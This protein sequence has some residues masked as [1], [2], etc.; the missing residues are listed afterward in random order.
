MSVTHTINVD[1]IECNVA[2]T[3]QVVF[4][5]K[6]TL[7]LGKFSLWLLGEGN[8]YYRRRW[9]LSYANKNIGIVQYMLITDQW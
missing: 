9:R 6:D 4:M 1:W 5:T 7:K 3:S 8:M 2:C